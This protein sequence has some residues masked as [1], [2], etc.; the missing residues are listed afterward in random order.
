[1]SFLRDQLRGEE[2]AKKM[3]EDQFTQEV[4]ALRSQTARLQ[5]AAEEL[6]QEQQKRR[7]A[8]ERAR[9]EKVFL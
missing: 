3:S 8:E 5:A 4:E 2:E 6:Q 7:A 1:L 9:E